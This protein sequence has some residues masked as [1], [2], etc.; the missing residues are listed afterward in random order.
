MSIPSSV[1]SGPSRPRRA[2]GRVLAALVMLLAVATTALAPASQEDA[3]ELRILVTNDD[4]IDSPGIA[5]LVTALAPLGKVWV[6]A[7]DANRSGSSASADGFGRPL[8]L[9]EHPIE[10]AVRACAVGGKPVDAAQFGI[11]AL[12]GGKPFDLVVSGIN[13]GANV[14]D[15]AHYSGT[16]GAAVAAVHCGVPAIAVSQ[17]RAIEGFERTARFTARFARVLME[18]GPAPGVIYAINVPKPPAEGAQQVVAARMGGDFAAVEGYVET[19]GAD[20]R[21][22]CRARIRLEPRAAEGTDTAAYVA[23]RITVTPLRFDWTDEDVLTDLAGW[24][25]AFE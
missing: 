13:D 17:D 9:A 18:H 6:S 2:R 8:P 20:G 12:G 19:L 25:L 15:L 3:R 16:V 1:W 23:G 22:T 24:D 11:L 14:G 7:P 21:G 5:A 4:G 10:G